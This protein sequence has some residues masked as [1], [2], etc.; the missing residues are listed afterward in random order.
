MDSPPCLLRA[1]YH[2]QL[3]NLRTPELAKAASRLIALAA[4]SLGS[5]ELSFLE[6]L[7]PAEA[8]NFTESL[9][10][11]PQ[12]RF[13]ALLN[14]RHP[15]QVV[16]S[17][18]SKAPQLESV[19]MRSCVGA[20]GALARWLK[21]SSDRAQPC[22]LRK[23]VVE[24]FQDQVIELVDALRNCPDL[25]DADLCATYNY[26][27]LSNATVNQIGQVV[28]GQAWKG[29]KSFRVKSQQGCVDVSKPHGATS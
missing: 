17:L 27:A 8:A 7:E 21:N 4:P 29:I 19:T 28:Q 1:L 20:A 11:L 15:R 10:R 25:T 18:L 9:P 5:L 13:L 3:T 16:A 22:Q 24:P 23:V 6:L 26:A 14:F 12:L 2:L